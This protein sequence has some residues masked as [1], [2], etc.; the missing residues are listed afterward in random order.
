MAFICSDSIENDACN[1]YSQIYKLQTNLTPTGAVAEGPGDRATHEQLKQYFKIPK[2]YPLE[3]FN[4]SGTVF[5]NL[6]TNFQTMES[7]IVGEAEALLFFT[8]ID[9]IEKT[10]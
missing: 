3:K 8:L 7:T 1:T 9:K 5:Y 6:N 10:R 2:E 4:S